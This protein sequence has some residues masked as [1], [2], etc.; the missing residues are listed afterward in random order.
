MMAT[1]WTVSIMSVMFLIVAQEFGGTVMMTTSMNLMIY[2]K[3]FIIEKLTKPPKKKAFNDGF[4]EGT[5]GCLY[6]NKPLDKT[7]LF[8]LKNTKF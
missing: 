6:Q 8:F 2:L 7:Q 4:L 1:N 5:V 3:E